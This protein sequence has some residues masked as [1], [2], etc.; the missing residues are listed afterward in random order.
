ML[1]C[2]RL[3][4]RLAELWHEISKIEQEKNPGI[5]QIDLD[6]RCVELLESFAAAHKTEVGIS[7]ITIKALED[8]MQILD[9]AKRVCA[10]TRRK[11][12]NPRDFF[13]FL[14]DKAKEISPDYPGIESSYDPYDQLWAITSS[15]EGTAAAN[16]ECH[17]LIDV[18]REKLG[19]T[20]EEL[21]DK[22]K[23]LVKEKSNA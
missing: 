11:L 6:E 14:H 5:S 3:A 12:N 16:D 17:K 8:S 19:W 4:L 13:R 10:A 2:D 22:W 15:Y 18:M 23:E 7:A 20:K 1:V 21:V 9:K